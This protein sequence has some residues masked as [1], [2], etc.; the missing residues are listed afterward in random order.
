[1]EKQFSVPKRGYVYH[2]HSR[3][4]HTS[5]KSQGKCVSFSFYILMSLDHWL[6]GGLCGPNEFGEVG[7]SLKPI[8]FPSFL[9]LLVHG[10]AFVT[11]EKLI[12]AHL[13]LVVHWCSK[14]SHSHY[15][16]RRDIKNPSALLMADVFSPL[17][18]AQSP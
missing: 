9:L 15:P 14:H 11:G 6:L 3:G 7:H 10:R 18:E 16:G 5:Q 13:I 8:C 2:C 1:M 12:S 4:E 17:N